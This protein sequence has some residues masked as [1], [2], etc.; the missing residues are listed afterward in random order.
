MQIRRRERN[1]R[2]FAFEMAS[3]VHK[4]KRHSKVEKRNTFVE[5]LLGNLGGKYSKFVEYEEHGWGSKKNLVENE[6]NF[7]GDVSCARNFANS[8]TVVDLSHSGIPGESK[9]VSLRWPFMPNNSPISLRYSIRAR[10]YP[11]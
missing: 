1:E 2:K 11:S 10:K 7:I 8:V 5:E 6:C 4:I 9:Y 3:P